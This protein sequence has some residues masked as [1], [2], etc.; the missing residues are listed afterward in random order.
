MTLAE[1]QVVLTRVL[2]LLLAPAV[3]VAPPAAGRLLQAAPAVIP[4]AAAAAAAAVAAAVLAALV[5]AAVPD[6]QRELQLGLQP[7][8]KRWRPILQAAHR[9]VLLVHVV[10]LPWLLLL[11][12]LLML[13]DPLNHSQ[14]R[15]LAPLTRFPA[16]MIPPSVC[17]LDGCHWR[18]CLRQLRG[19]QDWQQGRGA[20][21][22]S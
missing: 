21:H 15:I 22:L 16:V 5:A 9:G 6:V 11:L 17:W 10:Q 12:L 19:H 4:E 1:S 14:L 7:Q 20:R 18:R 3:A 8:G 13:M 2:S